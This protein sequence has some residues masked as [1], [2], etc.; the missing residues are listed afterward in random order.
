MGEDEVLDL[1][2]VTFIFPEKIV[3]SVPLGLDLDHLHKKRQIINMGWSRK[4]I[5]S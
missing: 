1:S 5:I 4:I 2:D 3:A